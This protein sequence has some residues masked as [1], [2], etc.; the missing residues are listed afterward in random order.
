MTEAGV[1]SFYDYV[2]RKYYF[3][4]GP[5]AGLAVDMYYD[6]ETFPKVAGAD[7]NTKST[8]VSYLKSLGAGRDCLNVF[9]KV[10]REYA[11]DIS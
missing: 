11:T 2:V 6:R 5:E 1:I 8:L 9:E 4:H 7:E 3:S 10:F